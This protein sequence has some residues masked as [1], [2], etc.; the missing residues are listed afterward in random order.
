[1]TG[2]PRSPPPYKGF[3]ERSAQGF[4]FPDGTEEF[5]LFIVILYG[6]FQITAY[7][8]YIEWSDFL[9]IADTPFSPSRVLYRGTVPY[10]GPGET[11]AV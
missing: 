3:C 2:T 8:T 9:N 11:G 4:R 6:F 7:A 1:M 5:R 10:S